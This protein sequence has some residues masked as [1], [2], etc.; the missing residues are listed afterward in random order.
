MYRLPLGR[1]HPDALTPP[2]GSEHAFR[3]EKPTPTRFSGNALLVSVTLADAAG[4]AGAVSQWPDGDESTALAEDDE[5]D[6][7]DEEPR[8]DEDEATPNTADRGQPIDLSE[9]TQL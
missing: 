6:A 3:G 7:I 4:A 9:I 5:D 1:N 8:D 2:E